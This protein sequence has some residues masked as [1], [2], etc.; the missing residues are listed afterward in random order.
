MKYITLSELASCVRRNIYKIPHDIDFVIGVPRSGMI[1]AGMVA[2]FI[3]VPLIDVDSFCAG[4]QPTGGGRLRFIEKDRTHKVL[5]LDDTV[6]RGHSMNKAKDKLMPY[7]DRYQFI[8]AAVYLEG[9]GSDAID[10]FLEDVRRYTNNFTQIVLYEWNIFHHIP[11][12]MDH[13]MYDMDG[14]LCVNPPDERKTEAYERYIEDAVPLFT[15]K[16]T[17]GS[18]V[19]YRLERYRDVTER[20]LKNNGIRY[21]DLRMFASQ[22]WDERNA[23]GIGPARFKAERYR[24]DRNAHLFVESDDYQAQRIHDLTLKPVLCVETNIM[25]GSD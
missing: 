20:W 15:P 5:V 13:C 16:M 8:Y 25:Y 6:F 17:I 10:F 18:I 19:T 3:N 2:E 22:S 23:S 7:R 24:E 12:I 9:R 11:S 1:P 21:A 4:A 14:V